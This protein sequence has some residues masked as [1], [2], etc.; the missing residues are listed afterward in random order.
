MR[1]SRTRKRYHPR[2]A[3]R[4]RAIDEGARASCVSDARNDRIMCGGMESFMLS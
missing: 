4:M 2:I 3:E 1:F